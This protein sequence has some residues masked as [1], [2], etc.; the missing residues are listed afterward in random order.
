MTHAH[1]RGASA[2]R[3]AW[4]I[5][6]IKET[7]AKWNAYYAQDIRPHKI[8]P[9]RRR[10]VATAHE[11]TGHFAS[12]RKRPA[13]CCSAAAQ[14]EVPRSLTAAEYEVDVSFAQRSTRQPPP[15]LQQNAKRPA[16][17]TPD[18]GR[19]VSTRVISGRVTRQQPRSRPRPQRRSPR[20]EPP[21]PSWRPQRQ[22]SS[23]TQRHAWP[24]RRA[25]PRARRPSWQ[26]PPRQRPA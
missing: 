12:R 18:T 23:R 5:D 11:S 13:F 16:P 8:D 24:S 7:L 21:R 19:F 2:R 25:W 14:R 9:T 3:Y 20:Q 26:R 4:G 6:T 1:A 22:P 10:K 15:L 17:G